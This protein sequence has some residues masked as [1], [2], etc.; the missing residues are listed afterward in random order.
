[1]KVSILK[2]KSKLCSISIYFKANQELNFKTNMFVI[3]EING[4]L[5]IRESTI[6]DN[7]V[8]KLSKSNQ[9]N[10]HSVNAE[11]FIGEQELLTE[12]GYFII[13]PIKYHKVLW[14]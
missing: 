1:M 11:N 13:E 3:K 6:L 4:C 5:L 7:K 2:T 12:D 9:L 10:Y 8:Y 14:R